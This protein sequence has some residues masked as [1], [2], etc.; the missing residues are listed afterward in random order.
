MTRTNL[1]KIYTNLYIYIYIFI[2][3]YCP[4]C[5][6]T[7]VTEPRCSVQ[8]IRPDVLVCSVLYV[9]HVPAL[10]IHVSAGCVRLY[11]VQ[12]KKTSENPPPGMEVVSVYDE[13]HHLLCVEPP[14]WHIQFNAERKCRLRFGPLDGGQ[15]LG[16]LYDPILFSL[17]SIPLQGWPGFPVTVHYRLWCIFDV[18]DCHKAF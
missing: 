12:S 4:Y 11:G 18:T 14:A 9:C 17:L 13:S 10:K 3:L 2:S 15:A 5:G 6:V 16:R 1:E 8:V 7:V